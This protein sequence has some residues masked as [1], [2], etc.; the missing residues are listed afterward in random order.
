MKTKLTV[1]NNSRETIFIVPEDV[2][3]RIEEAG[4]AL[5]AIGDFKGYVAM[6]YEEAQKE[7]ARSKNYYCAGAIETFFRPFLE[8]KAFKFGIIPPG[9]DR[10]GYIAFNLPD[11]FN[12]TT[13]ARQVADSLKSMMTLLNARIEIN[14]WALSKNR[15]FVFPVN[16][17][18]YSDVR[19]NPLFIMRFFNL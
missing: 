1:A 12:R 6:R 14:T 4:V 19:Q 3:L 5:R 13:E 9:D 8:A 15:A 10:E 11:P 16:V 7:C 18:T 17:T 2:I